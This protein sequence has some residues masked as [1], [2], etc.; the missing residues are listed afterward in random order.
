MQS[1]LM[2]LAEAG[3]NIVAGY[4]LALVT[5]FLVFPM[6]GFA[7]SVGENLLIGGI[8][9]IVSLIRSFVLRR[10]FNALALD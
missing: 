3:A 7:A 1:R 9:T 2:S 5:Q 4:V 10:L 8:F 6:F